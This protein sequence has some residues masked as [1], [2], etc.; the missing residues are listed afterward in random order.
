MFSARLIEVNGDVDAVAKPG[1]IPDFY[2]LHPMTLDDACKD[3]LKAC[4]TE[5]YDPGTMKHTS[6]MDFIEFIEPYEEMVERGY[7]RFGNVI[8]CV[9][10]AWKVDANVYRLE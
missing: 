2:S 3:A 7:I 4:Y 5:V 8:V 10:E 1:I 6:L 9:D